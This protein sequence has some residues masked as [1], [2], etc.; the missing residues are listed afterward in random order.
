MLL[1]HKRALTGDD[2]TTSLGDL[3]QLGRMPVENR[4]PPASLNPGV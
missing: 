3:Q 4:H 1:N 2:L